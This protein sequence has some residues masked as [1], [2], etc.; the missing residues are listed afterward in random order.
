MAGNNVRDI[1]PD[2]LHAVDL[3]YDIR[4]LHAEMEYHKAKVIHLWSGN[5]SPTKRTGQDVWFIRGSNLKRRDISMNLIDRDIHHISWKNHNIKHYIKVAMG[6]Y[7]KNKEEKK[8]SWQEYFQSFLQSHTDKKTW[9]VQRFT[10]DTIKE[11]LECW[12]SEWQ[13][14]EKN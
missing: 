13:K 14:E 6:E 1:L 12:K 3:E 7:L 5:Q 4:K 10:Y 11:W 9:D 2:R 8:W